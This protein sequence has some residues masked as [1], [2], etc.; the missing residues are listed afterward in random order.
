MLFRSDETQRDL[1]HLERIGA[2]AH[3]RQRRRERRAEL[4]QMQKSPEGR[5]PGMR[6][7][8]LPGRADGNGLFAAS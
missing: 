1:R 4:P 5:L 6:A 2:R 3:M 7:E 8:L